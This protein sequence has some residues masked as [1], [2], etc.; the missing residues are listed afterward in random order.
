MP[1]TQVLGQVPLPDDG[2]TLRAR[3]LALPL[4]LAHRVGDGLDEVREEIAETY[5]AQRPRERAA[6]LAQ[7]EHDE[8]DL[9]YAGQ[10][11]GNTYTI[12]NTPASIA[13]TVSAG[14]GTDAVNVGGSAQTLDAIL[15]AVTVNGK[16]ANTTV[17]YN[18]QNSTAAN[19]AVTKPITANA[20]RGPS[21]MSTQT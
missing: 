1:L 8:A 14:S 7:H 20:T 3:R 18:D 4:Q 6:R 13:L 2:L 19:D 17:N 10:S 5:P 11:G 16:G 12:E 15:G 21:C 9:H